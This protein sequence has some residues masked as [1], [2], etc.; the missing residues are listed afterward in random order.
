M[1]FFGKTNIDF[2]KIRFQ[3]YVLSG[4]VILAGV[5]SLIIKGVDYGVDFRGGTELTLHF[6][7]ELQISDIR[8]AL[9]TIGLGNSEIKSFGTEGDLLIRT[10]EQ[11]EG[12]IVA[13]RIKAS[14]SQA[15]PQT[16]FEV[17]KQYKISPKISVE[18]RRDALYAI[19]ASLVVILIYVGMRFK[20]VYGFGAVLALFHDV[21]V[22][23]GILSL[24]DGVIPINLEITQEVIAAFLTIIGVSVNDTVVVF[25]RIRENEKIYRSKPLH[26]VINGSLND[27][28][29]RTIITN[30]T[31]FLVLLTLLIF[32]G[33]VTRGFA[34]TLT[35]GTIAG[36][37][38]SVYIASAVVL[39]WTNRKKNPR[40]R[41]E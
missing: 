29:S 32:G 30:G 26:D 13:D 12:T 16:K 22:T 34:F 19:I 17:L 9:G 18:L 35:V 36:T 6:D 23:L 21:A 33:E 7:Q 25:D 8:N 39:D 24:L 14:I 15:F 28:L 20:F 3:M 2:L 1:R 11:A 27:T 37:Y 31:V 5:V 38:S 4:L 40:V 41:G 10:T